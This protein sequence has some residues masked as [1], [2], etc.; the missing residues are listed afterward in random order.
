MTP[1]CIKEE[2][3]KEHDYFWIPTHQ[4]LFTEQPK[5]ANCGLFDIFGMIFGNYNIVFNSHVSVLNGGRG[6]GEIK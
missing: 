6:E 1:T 5:A 2:S 4:S 3:C